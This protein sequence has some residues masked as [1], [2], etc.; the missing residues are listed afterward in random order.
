MYLLPF[1]E[2]VAGTSRIHVDD[3]VPVHVRKVCTMKIGIIFHSYSGITRSIAERVQAATG[4][5]LIEARPRRPYTT[6]TAYSFGCI[7]ARAEEA[8]PIEPSTIDVAPYD[9]IV[10]GTPVWAWKTTPATNAAIN[11][12]Q[13][14]AGKRAVVFATCGSQAGDAIPI[15]E[16]ALGKKGVSVV[17][18][19]VFSRKDATGDQ[20]IAGLIH[21]VNT[22]AAS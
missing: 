16:R 11:A 1:R 3:N 22:A 2:S 13:N 15:M 9:L 5:D 6:L 14:C 8:E 10:L 21:M 20:K 18:H 19:M 12:L 7:R 4:G 17:G